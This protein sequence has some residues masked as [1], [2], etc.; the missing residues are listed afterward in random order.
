MVTAVSCLV[1]C[2]AGKFSP[3]NRNIIAPG[4]LCL[5]SQPP[6][7][8]QYH[9]QLA[10]HVIIRFSYNKC[11]IQVAQVMEHCPAA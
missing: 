6:D 9:L 4:F 8:L 11:K 3:L 1:K 2:I 10:V 7:C 5:D